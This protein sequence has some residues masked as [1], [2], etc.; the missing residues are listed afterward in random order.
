MTSRLNDLKHD[1]LHLKFSDFYC[2]HVIKIL[3]IASMTEP[4]S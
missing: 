4:A 3:K 1:S 2:P